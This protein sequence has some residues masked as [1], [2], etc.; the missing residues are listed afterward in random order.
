M[1]LIADILLVAGAL[2]AAVYCMVLARRLQKLND[3]EGGMGNAIAVLSAQVDDMT[4]ALEGAR[5]SAQDSGKTLG[6]L[7]RRAE[8]VA[9]RLELMVASLHDLPA[10]HPPEEPARPAAEPEPK[11]V[12]R[13]HVEAA[14]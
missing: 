14:E 3:L 8:G 7:T 2:G 6:D 10:A 5:D 12:W 9:Q 4:R 11:L 1:T 13:R